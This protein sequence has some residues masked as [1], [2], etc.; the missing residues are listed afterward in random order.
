MNLSKLLLVL[1][2]FCFCAITVNAQAKKTATVQSKRIVL[3]SQQDSIS[4][5]L[6]MDVANNITQNEIPLTPEAF[7]QAVLDVLAKNNLQLTPAQADAQLQAL[8]QTMMAK[9]QERQAREQVEQAMQAENNKAVGMS[10][11]AENKKRPGIVTTPSGLQYEALVVGTGKQP[12][13][14]SRVTV[15]YTGTLLNGTIFDS[16]VQ[17][18]EPIEFPL[19][20][21]ISGWTEGLQL[22]KEGGKAKLFIPSDLAYG[23]RQA[24]ELIAPGSTLIFEVELIKVSD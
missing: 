9:H 24:G 10:F 6:G 17:R 22:M 16:S 19:N 11:L 15:H 3:K 20:Q 8:Q 14:T 5:A 21:V 12:K 7:T 4:Y 2:A 13:E 18:G 1:A 23:D